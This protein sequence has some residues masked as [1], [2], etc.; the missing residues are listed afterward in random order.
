LKELR[1]PLE[2]LTVIETV[3]SVDERGRFERLFCE[4]EYKTLRPSLRWRQINLS[5]TFQK[6]VIRGMHFQRPP[7]AEAKLIRCLRGRI[8]DVA[9]DVRAGSPTFLRWHGIVLDQDAPQEIFIPEGFAHGFQALTDDVQLLYLHTASWNRDHEG[10]LH[11]GDPV[12]AIEWPQPVTQVSERDR[13]TPLLDA[14]FGG[15]SL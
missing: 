11:Y 7:S 1:T 8:F 4:E 6:G 2:G 12:L 15:V 14:G 5:Q 10:R 13:S 9:V 3:P